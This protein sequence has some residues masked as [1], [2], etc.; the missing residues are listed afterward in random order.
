MFR[1][2]FLSVV[3]LAIL[4][5]ACQMRQFN[6]GSALN[7]AESEFDA[8]ESEKD[9]RQKALDR[10][11]HVEHKIA[12]E[13]FR[14]FPVGNQGM[15]A[16]LY[17]ILPGLSKPHEEIWG[18][19]KSKMSKLGLG[20][21]PV[22]PD[23]PF[24]LGIGWS[25]VSGTIPINV[26]VF[27]CGACH[28]G[29]VLGPN[30]R[31]IHLYG[32]PN[33]QFD[34][35]GFTAAVVKSTRSNT[36]N[37][38]NIAQAIDQH[39]KNS[40]W[41]Y[42]H[43]RPN[44]IV[45][46]KME[47]AFIK[48]TAKSVVSKIKATS[49]QRQTKID[50]V[51]GNGPYKVN[52]GE[53]P[54]LPNPG[55]NLDGGNP[56]RLDAFATAIALLSDKTKAPPEQ[57]AHPKAAMV[58]IMSVWGQGRR[59]LGQWDGSIRSEVIRNMGAE[60][61]VVGDPDGVSLENAKLTTKLLVELPPP[62]YPFRVNMAW[63]N[64]GKEHF[65]T[66]CATCHYDKT[67]QV[68]SPEMIGTDPNRANIFTSE[69]RKLLI[70]GLRLSCPEKKDAVCRGIKDEDILKPTDAP[71]GYVAFPLDGIWARA[72]YLHNGSVPTLMHLLVPSLRDRSEARKFWR[73]NIAY[74]EKFVGFEWRTNKGP[75]EFKDSPMVDQNGAFLTAKIFDVSLEGSSNKGHSANLRMDGG[76][77]SDDPTT[78]R[79]KETLELLEYLKTL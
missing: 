64:A 45:S 70:A 17:K 58:D 34:A 36:F 66:H 73:G 3:S 44:H 76:L 61:G 78:T 28:I 47:P 42:G 24:P 74:D 1:T 25:K 13:W 50:T 49:E 33:T 57:L 7:H 48:A 51:L 59:T 6:E 27:T 22:F 69:G 2:H 67:E 72:P 63:A 16:V 8:W 11:L 32:A 55:G 35:H 14:D 9:R 41:L 31:V 43:N 46:E 15:P 65:K 30:N 56:G 40:N 4:L 5:T 71:R 23:Y 18:A 77:W 75:A 37:A 68:F 21:H 79:G 20:P 62:P 29:R 52:L 39:S 53:D 12:F 26:G 19:E 54:K 10:Y 60:L 38:D